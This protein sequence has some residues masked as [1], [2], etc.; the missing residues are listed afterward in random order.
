VF[1]GRQSKFSSSMHGFGFC[2]L[3]TPLNR[4]SHAETHWSGNRLPGSVRLRKQTYQA[5]A[6]SKFLANL[7]I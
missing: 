7:E 4:F 1:R 3:S 2:H 6:W 5:P